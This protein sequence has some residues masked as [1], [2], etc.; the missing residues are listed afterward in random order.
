MQQ[1]SINVNERNFSAW[2]NSIVILY[3]YVET[4][5][6]IWQPRSLFTVEKVQ[7]Q[8][9]YY[10]YPYLTWDNMIK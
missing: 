9:S 5:F 6:A 1:V 7:A 10:Q 8:M 3:F 2:E 4:Q